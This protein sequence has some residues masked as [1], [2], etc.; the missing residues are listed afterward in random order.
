[1]TLLKV[2]RLTAE[3]PIRFQ[4]RQFIT[5]LQGRGRPAKMRMNVQKT[6]ISEAQKK[7]KV[8]AKSLKISLE[9]ANR[10]VHESTVGR[11]LNQKGV[12]GLNKVQET[13]WS[14]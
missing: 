7:D 5:A 10:F 3:Q 8:T 1:M 12:H 6:I 4:R 14:P 13:W 2:K 11:S 9:L